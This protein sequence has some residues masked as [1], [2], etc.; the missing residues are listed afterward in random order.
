M[1]PHQLYELRNGYEI[2]FCPKTKVLYFSRGEFNKFF[3][4][5][6]QTIETPL[7]FVSFHKNTH[8]GPFHAT[9]VSLALSLFYWEQLSA[10]PKKFN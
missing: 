4:V 9:P 10:G 2:T 1:K 8:Y 6:V 3:N 5:F 7:S